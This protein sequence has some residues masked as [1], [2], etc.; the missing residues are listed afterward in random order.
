MGS[1]ACKAL[2]AEGYAPVCIDNLVYGHEWA[3]KWGV[4]E[5]GD[6]ADTAFLRRVF[7]C[8][9]PVA[10]MHFAAYAYV[11]ESVK[12]PKKYYSNNVGGTLSLLS[13]MQE[14]GCKNLVFSSTCATYGIPEQVP[15]GE[16]AEQRPINPYGASKLIVER[17]IRDYHDAYDLS[18]IILRY[19]NAAGADPEAEIG[20]S[21]NPETHLI[22]LILDVAMGR[23]ESISIFGADYPTADGTCIRD[24]IHVSDLA[25]AH[26]LA[27][28]K[29]IVSPPCLDIFNLGSAT[30]FSVLE[31]LERCRSVTGHPIPNRNEA[32]RQGDPAQLVASNTHAKETLNWSPQLSSLESIISTAW[33]W[34]KVRPTS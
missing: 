18:A 11:G 6:I 12:D 16:H 20:E 34:H 10:V 13:V 26:V 14:F 24:F 29:L 33:R 8:Y 22:P 5:K 9:E 15:I 25:Q 17:V 31:V 19:F 1:H 3:V 23:S 28:Q 30:G 27:L 32:R 2:A 7:K 4:L 21:H